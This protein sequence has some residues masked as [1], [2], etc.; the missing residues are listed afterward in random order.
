MPVLE[1]DVPGKLLEN[2]VR[3]RHEDVATRFEYRPDIETRGGR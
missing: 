2:F 1:C 3:V